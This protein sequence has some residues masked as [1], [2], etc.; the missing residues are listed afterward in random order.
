MNAPWVHPQELAVHL[1]RIRPP[2]MDMQTTTYRICTGKTWLYYLLLTDRT[3]DW[4]LEHTCI[5]NYTHHLMGRHK[6][7]GSVTMIGGQPRRRKNR[8]FSWADTNSRAPTDFKSSIHKIHSEISYL[9]MNSHIRWIPSQNPSAIHDP[10]Y[11]QW[12]DPAQAAASLQSRDPKACDP[13]TE[14]TQNDQES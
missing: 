13:V 7:S 11:S 14:E 4:M 1:H 5:P 12:R 8:R 10:T 6:D 3:A 9:L 2:K